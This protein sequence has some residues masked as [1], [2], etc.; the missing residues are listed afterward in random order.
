VPGR[1]QVACQRGCASADPVVVGEDQPIFRDGIVHVPAQSGF[2]V[3]GTASDAPELI[4]KIRARRPDVAVAD[5]QLPP[6]TPTMGGAPCQ[7]SSRLAGVPP[8]WTCSRDAFHF[9]SS[10]ISPRSS[11]CLQSRRAST[12]SAPRRSQTSPNMHGGGCAGDDGRGRRPPYDRSSRR[13]H[14]RSGHP[15]RRRARR[16]ARADQ[17]AVPRHHAQGLP[18]AHTLTRGPSASRDLHAPLDRRLRRPSGTI[19]V[20][21]SADR[22]ASS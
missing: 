14:W 13:L 11:F 1:P 19:A 12:S 6:T 7:R 16:H 18:S 10:S 3:A 8:R 4:R 22:R 17:S 9:D 2:E 5:I 15:C 20:R 21:A